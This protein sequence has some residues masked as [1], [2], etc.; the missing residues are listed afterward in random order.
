V[1]ADETYFDLSPTDRSMAILDRTSPVAFHVLWDLVGPVDFE[2]L[3]WAWQ[4][5]TRVHPI[6]GCTVDIQADATWHPGMD[7]APIRRLEGGEKQDQLISDAVGLPMDIRSGPPVRLT[8]IE[9]ATDT[10]RLVLAAH[11][12]AFDG[13]ASVLLLEDLRRIYLDRVSAPGPAQVPD[14][15]PRTVREALRHARLPVLTKQ[16]IVGKSLDRWR[17]VPPSTHIDPSA[18]PSEVA[19]DYVTIDMSPI[20]SALD[21]QRRRNSWSVDAVLIGLLEAAWTETFGRESQGASVWLVAHDLRPGLGAKRGIGNMSGTE[22]IAIRQPEARPVER[23]I[24]QAAVEMAAIKSSFPG[25]GPE[26]MATSWAWMPSAV[27]NRGAD[28][29]IRRGQRQRYTRT[30]SNL[31]RLPDS[32]TDWGPARM[33]RIRFLGPLAQGPYNSFIAFAQGSSSWLTARVSPDWLTREHTTQLEA[34]MRRVCRV[35]R[36]TF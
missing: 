33:D 31:S 35:G 1:R 21:E 22:P 23:V 6:L 26:L 32:L 8:A 27:L 28:A 19:T 11:H 18:G 29:M 5:L 3:D 15:S 24:E 14:L 2:A 12:A 4:A 7:L 9:E 13:V 20:L 36:R 30:L 34:A 25:L 17:R 10:L 16:S